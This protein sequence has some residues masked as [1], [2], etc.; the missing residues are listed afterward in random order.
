[1]LRLWISITSL[2]GFFG[3]WYMLAQSFKPA[4]TQPL[5]VLAYPTLAAV[6]AESPKAKLPG[7]GDKPP[8]ERPTPSS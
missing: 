7:P 6:L 5:S 1:M 8:T 3:A 4:Q 2:F